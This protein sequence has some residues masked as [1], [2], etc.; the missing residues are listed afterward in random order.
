M[1]DRDGFTKPILQIVIEEA[2][3]SGIE[4]VCIVGQPGAEKDFLAHFRPIPPELQ[5]RFQGM[6]VVTQAGGDCRTPQFR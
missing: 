4:Q 3:D 6:A 5:D 2:L 1:V